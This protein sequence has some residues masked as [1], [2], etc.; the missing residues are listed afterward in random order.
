[1]IPTNTS[2]DPPSAIPSRE[3]IPITLLTV[4]DVAKRLKLS[5]RSVWRLLSSGLI[6]KPIKIGGSIRWRSNE[7]EL[8][9]LA[10]PTGEKSTSEKSFKDQMFDPLDHTTIRNGVTNHDK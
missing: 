4:N 7:F 8:W 6:V 1:M 5:T 3:P 2:K 10:H 9:I